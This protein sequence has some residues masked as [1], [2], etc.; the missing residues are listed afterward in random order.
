[1]T[2][3]SPQVRS[4]D[5]SWRDCK[6]Q[7]RKDHRWESA[8]LLDRDQKERLFNDHIR[9]LEQKRREAFYQL[10][11]ETTEVTLTSTWKE[12]RKVIKED[13]RC[14]KFSTSERKTER[15]FK[16]YLQQKLMMA[17]S[18][19]RELLKETKIVTYKSKQMIQENEQHLKDI[20][21]VLENDKRYFVLDC[22][23]DEREKLLDTYLD[24]L[25]K[26]G[27]PPPP[28]ATEP[29]RRIK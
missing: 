4:A 22:V 19:F 3:F 28:T 6:R 20:L 26:R 21:A 11:D 7:L 29:S 10:L 15:E 1:M 23:P 16:D 9:Q 17:K 14:S 12:I 13:P 2:R 25:H 24:E 5:Q 8:D 27:P 18:D